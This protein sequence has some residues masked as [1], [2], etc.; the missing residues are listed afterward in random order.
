MASLYFATSQKAT[1]VTHAAVGAFTGPTDLNLVLGKTNR[2]EV[3]RITP[4]G[5]SA[6]YDVSV[7]GRISTLRLVRI[8]VSLGFGRGERRGRKA[9]AT[10]ETT[11]AIPL[12]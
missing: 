7:Y 4:E 5:L 11:R 12:R 3:Y 1:G 10:C 8:A 2:V 6:V 9:R